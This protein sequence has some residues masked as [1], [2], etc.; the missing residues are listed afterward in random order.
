MSGNEGTYG[1]ALQRLIGFLNARDLEYEA[2]TETP[3]K[4]LFADR[5]SV[6]SFLDS[7]KPKPAN[8]SEVLIEVVLDIA[9]PTPQRTFAYLIDVLNVKLPT[10]MMVS[11][12]ADPETTFSHVPTDQELETFM[13][14][15]QCLCFDPSCE[16]RH[17]L[18]DICAVGS[19]DWLRIKAMSNALLQLDV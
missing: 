5:E 12:T 15:L 17:L 3:D 18:A 19:P 1:L 9:K 16:Q 14:S 13:R 11:T 7:L 6:I 10:G 4:I 2:T 8:Y